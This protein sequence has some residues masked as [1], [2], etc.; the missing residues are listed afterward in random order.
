MDPRHCDIV[1]D[2]AARQSVSQSV[3]AF[4]CSLTWY[5]CFSSRINHISTGSC[6]I[7]VQ[8]EILSAMLS[9]DV[10]MSVSEQ[11]TLGGAPAMLHQGGPSF[12]RYL[13]EYFEYWPTDLKLFPAMAHGMVHP[14]SV[15]HQEKQRVQISRVPRQFSREQVDQ[16]R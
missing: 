10:V 13:P 9:S 14:P 1:S 8:K 11:E 6:V 16:W 2:A 3:S 7:G 4:S 15:G 12:T 5:L